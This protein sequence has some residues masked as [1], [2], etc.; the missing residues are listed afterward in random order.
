MTRGLTGEERDR[1][2]GDFIELVAA[3]D[4]MLRAQAVADAGYFAANSGRAVDADEV[5]A[6]EAA[7]LAAYRWQY[8][9]SGVGHL[10]FRQGAV[11]IDHGK[12]GPAYSGSARH[13]A[14]SRSLAVSIIE[15]KKGDSSR[16][17]TQ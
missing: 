9:H 8:I 1:A 7:F 14:P 6:I 5:R 4:G 12:P 16:M 13:V 2:V 3:V 11:G 10:Q 15:Q 17:V